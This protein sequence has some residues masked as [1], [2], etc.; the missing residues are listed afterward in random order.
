MCKKNGKERKIL[1]RSVLFPKLNFRVADSDTIALD[2][3]RDGDVLE[4]GVGGDGQGG[5]EQQRERTHLQPD[6]QQQTAGRGGQSEGVINEAPLLFH[7][8]TSET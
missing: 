3:A 5:E 1:T 7:C 2:G 4:S 8:H 6:G